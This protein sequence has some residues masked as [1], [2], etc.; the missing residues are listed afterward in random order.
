[1]RRFTI[2]KLMAAV[3]LAAANFWAIRALLAADV[4]QSPTRQMFAGLLPLLDAAA[5]AG[6]LTI[7]RHRLALQRRPPGPRGRFAAVFCL[8][9]V[10]LFLALVVACVF[11]DD[12]LL[13]Y[14]MATVGP[15]ERALRSLGVDTVSDSP[16]LRYG[17]L[18]A[19]LGVVLSGP[20]LILSWAVAL[21][22][23]RYQL[24]VAARPAA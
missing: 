24:V 3:A 10:G 13:A 5:V 6:Y 11:A 18:P 8:A 21:L 4:P 1:M 2:G 23:S 16:V 22:A 20:P 7:A 19:C 14:V 9:G 17:L 12:T 15:F